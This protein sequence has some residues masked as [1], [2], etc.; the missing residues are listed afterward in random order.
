[1]KG[2]FDL[3]ISSGEWSAYVAHAQ[4]CGGC[5]LAYRQYQ[6]CETGQ[7]LHAEYTSA[8]RL[9]NAATR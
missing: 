2:K 6:R 3:A 1:M 8:R 5:A 4:H 7:R 9:V